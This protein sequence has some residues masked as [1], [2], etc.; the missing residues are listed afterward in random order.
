VTPEANPSNDGADNSFRSASRFTLLAICLLGLHL[1]LHEI[2]RISY[3]FDESSS[4][5]TIQF[6]W[7]QMLESVS[8]NVHPPVFYTLLKLWGSLFGTGP[9]SLRVFSVAFGIAAIPLSAIFMREALRNVNVL[10]SSHL[11]AP[12]CAAILIATSPIHIVLS[13]QARMYSL[14][15]SLALTAG[16][17]LLRLHNGT[18][19]LK[20]NIAGFSVSATL[21][22]LTHYYGILTVFAFMCLCVGMMWKSHSDEER[23]EDHSRW[24]NTLLASLTALTIPWS[25]WASIFVNQY[26]QVRKE[27]WIPE[28]NWAHGSQVLHSLSGAD[29]LLAPS[30]MSAF[31]F[32][33]IT[34]AI[35]IFPY[36]S[37]QFPESL[38]SCAAI[39]PVA[40]A[41]AQTLLFRSVVLDR[42]LILA[43]TFLLMG[44]CLL[45]TRIR[46]GVTSVIILGS[47]VLVGLMSGYRCID[48]RSR[49]AENS[50]MREACLLADRWK[51]DGGIIWVGASMVHP[52]AQRYA[53]SGKDVY[54]LD[55][56]KAYAHYLGGPLLQ[57]NEYLAAEQIHSS[58]IDQLIAIDVE[59][60]FL[61]E[62]TDLGALLPGWNEY[63]QRSFSES[64]GQPCRIIVR[65]FRRQSSATEARS[66][67]FNTIS[68]PGNVS[69]Q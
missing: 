60:L 29:R 61:T 32:L 24:R 11:A 35:V 10:R 48:A 33:V 39:V 68:L 7:R 25:L 30:N 45:G 15:I 43:Q 64:F 56:G 44:V 20:L 28:L 58:L 4:W 9:V 41:V 5:K 63:R 23:G 50:G 19:N 66:E 1:R 17:C 26:A 55:R 52:T 22:T 21:L 69:I 31:I 3:W 34:A 18:G 12:H 57:K 37:R 65:D 54:V 16:I 49:L 42:Y 47:A 46:P 62:K 2:Q 27:Y 67:K 38:C 51:Q 53:R 59:G 14:G 8:S 13:A 36:Y 40:T 6:S